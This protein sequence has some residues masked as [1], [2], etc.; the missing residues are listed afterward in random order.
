[1]ADDIEFHGKSAIVTGGASGIGAATVRELARRGADVTI[2]DIAGQAGKEL[3][4]ELSSSGFKVAFALTD[5]TS[6]V[7]VRRAVEAAQIRSGALNF[8]VNAAGGDP[9]RRNGVDMT[10]LDVA[11]WTKT[12]ELSLTGVFLPM[13]H[14]V[15]AMR[16][17]GGGT[18]VNVSS[19][20]GLR[21]SAG[22]TIAYHAAKAGVVHMTRWAAVTYGADKIRVNCV[23]PGL[24]MTPMVKKNTKPERQ[25]EIL[26]KLHVLHRAVEPEEQ[27]EAIIWLLSGNSAMITGNVV[28]VDG[29]WNAR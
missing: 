28:P 20:A 2:A 24:T 16:N 18:I 6:E 8:A 17:T 11:D 1:M 15:T 25:A 10:M 22:S 19:M 26:G 3:A 7:D 23:A 9:G 14:E 13:K 5:V 4:D 21:Y 12:V 29:G 27:A